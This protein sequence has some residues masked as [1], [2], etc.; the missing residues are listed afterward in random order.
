[1]RQQT[2][3]KTMM[4][5]IT[6]LLL[7]VMATATSLQAR[8]VIWDVRAGI[9][10][11]QLLCH[12]KNLGSISAYKASLGMT[13]PLSN[14]C[15]F[16]FPLEYTRKGGKVKAMDLPLCEFSSAQFGMQ[17]GY[18]VGI[19]PI[20]LNMRVGSYA[21]TYFDKKIGDNNIRYLSLHDGEIG[22][23]GGIDVE[24][25]H[26]VLSVEYQHGLTKATKYSKSDLYSSALY[27][28]LGYRF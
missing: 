14:S 23:T 25:R 6:M 8:R 2:S 18:L 11:S 13:V 3:N 16:Y 7:L 19:G 27:V 22:L 20:D 9:G 12:D 21:A 10:M 17:F 4:K 1:M 15:R 26:Y 24:Y 5:K 28:T